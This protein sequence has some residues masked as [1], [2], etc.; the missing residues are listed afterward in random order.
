MGLQWIGMKIFTSPG[1]VPGTSEAF[2]SRH[3]LLLQVMWV[4][5]LSVPVT[6]MTPAASSN[7][8]AN[9]VLLTAAPAIIATTEQ[10]GQ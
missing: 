1:P 7:Y 5:V 10:W 8:T 6:A 3:L 9:T 2:S 4:R